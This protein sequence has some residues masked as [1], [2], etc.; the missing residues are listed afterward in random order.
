M[1]VNAAV[2]ERYSAAAQD[3]E[4]ALCCPIADYDPAFLQAIPDA[5]LER[6]YGCGD[7]SRFVKSGDV[8]LDL[9]SGGGKICFI[10]SQIVGAAGKVIGVD[11]NREMLDL[12]RASAPQVAAH[13]G[14]A[15]CEFVVGNIQDLALDLEQ[16]ESWL[17]II[18]SKRV[19]IYWRFAKRNNACDALADDC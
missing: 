11:R 15:N 19:K 12:A 16:V 10:A 7:P 9:G 5:V 8:V 2:Q 13:T 3:R 6:D 4:E 1:D 18:R 17:L 14:Y